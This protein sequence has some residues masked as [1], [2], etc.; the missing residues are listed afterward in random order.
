VTNFERTL[1]VARARGVITSGQSAALLAI[2]AEPA[3]GNGSVPVTGAPQ[4]DEK[5]RLLTGFGDIF[6]TIG[7][8]LFFGGLAHFASWLG[9]AGLAVVFAVAAWLLAEFFTRRQRMALPS[10][11]L[12]VVFA[13]SVFVAI[14][15]A[16]SGIS[17]VWVLMA[18]SRPFTFAFAGLL[19]F[20][21]AGLHYWRFRVPIAPAAGAVALIPCLL[22]FVHAG[23]EPGVAFAAQPVLLAGYGMLVFALAMAFDLSDPRRLTRRSDIAFWLHML[24][25]A[26]IVHPLLSRFT[27]AGSAGAD[28]ATGPILG[29]FFA[30][31]IVAV[32]IDRRALLVSSLIYVGIAFGTLVRG[33]GWSDAAPLTMLALGVLVL[34]LSGAWH[35]LRRALLSLLPHR[36]AAR[37]RNSSTASPP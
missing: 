34:L 15:G 25:A 32:L 16:V 21:A 9:L 17:N 22:G 4:D 1:A 18:D 8:G 6:V 33:A 5:L 13:C 3:H 12:F 19:T 11:V 10:I 28:V 23:L 27:P 31:G 14:V 36:L 20:V 30:L 26:L 37:L 35:P 29:V 24:A 2:A 7:L